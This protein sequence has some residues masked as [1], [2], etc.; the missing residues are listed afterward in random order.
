MQ[1]VQ[2]SK[3]FLLTRLFL[4]LIFQVSKIRKCCFLTK[5]K[6]LSRQSFGNW[7]WSI[8]T[9]ACFYRDAWFAK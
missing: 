7:T 8:L 2:D 9:F 6:P 1:G 5:I 3:W 4:L